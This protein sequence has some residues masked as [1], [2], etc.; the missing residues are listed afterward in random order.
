[1]CLR[2]PGQVTLN[3]NQRFPTFSHSC[4]WGRERSESEREQECGLGVVCERS[5]G[6]WRRWASGVLEDYLEGGLK[7]AGAGKGEGQE[8]LVLACDPAWEAANYEAQAHNPDAAA[9][10]VAGRAHVLQA[11]HGSTLMRPRALTRY[12]ARLTR[13]DDLGHL[14]PMQAPDRIADWLSGALRGDD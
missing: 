12:G 5:G 6:D 10:Q 7:A 3:R 13:M 1:M 14:A 2:V 8:K 11:G 9:R 4:V